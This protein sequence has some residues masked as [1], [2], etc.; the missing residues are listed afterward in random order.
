MSRDTPGAIRRRL[1]QIFGSS[2]KVQQQSSKSLTILDRSEE[3]EGDYDFRSGHG[4][5]SK[6]KERPKSLSVKDRS[7]LYLTAA[8]PAPPP[9]ILKKSNSCSTSKRKSSKPEVRM[10]QLL[11]QTFNR[12]TEFRIVSAAEFHDLNVISS[13]N[14]LPSLSRSHSQKQV[15]QG[16]ESKLDSSDL[17]A[18]TLSTISTIS[19]RLSLT[20]GSIDSTE[21]TVSP[22][23]SLS[24]ERRDLS[25]DEDNE[26]DLSSLNNDNAEATGLTTSTLDSPFEFGTAEG[27][28]GDDNNNDKDN[29]GDDDDDDNAQQQLPEL[30]HLSEDS[31]FSGSLSFKQ[32]PPITRAESPLQDAEQ[33]MRDLEAENARLLSE[34]RLLTAMVSFRE[35]QLLQAKVAATSVYKTL[36]PFDSSVPPLSF[37]GNSEANSRTLHHP[38]ISWMA[39]LSL[40]AY[41]SPMDTRRLLYDVWPTK[42]LP[43]PSRL[44]FFADRDSDTWAYGYSYPSSG[45]AAIVFR[46]TTSDENW[47]TNMNIKMT[48][49]VAE[50]GPWK[51]ADLPVGDMQ[52]HSGFNRA[53]QSVWPSIKRFIHSF[54]LKNT[55]FSLTGHSLGGALASLCYIYIT[56]FYP[57]VQVVQAV[58]FGQPRLANASVVR[59][60][61]AHGRCVLHRIRNQS[62]GVPLIPP[63]APLGFTHL[64]GVV[65]LTA[66]GMIVQNKPKAQ[67]AALRYGKT[68]G[69]SSVTDHSMLE[70]VSLITRG[71]NTMM[72]IGGSLSNSDLAQRTLFARTLCVNLS[73]LDRFK[74]LRS[75]VRYTISVFNPK[76]N[77]IRGQTDVVNQLDADTVPIN[78]IV[79][80]YPV[81]IGDLFVVHIHKS[82]H[83]RRLI[84]AASFSIHTAQ[85]RTPEFTLPM[86]YGKDRATVASLM[87]SFELSSP[88]SDESG[89]IPEHRKRLF[90]HSLDTVC[91]L[92]LHN[93]PIDRLVSSQRA[94]PDVLAVF[95]DAITKRALNVDS[96]FDGLTC[97][98]FWNKLRDAMHHL[99]LSYF[100]LDEPPSSAM[101]LRSFA[102]FLRTLSEPICTFALYPRWLITANSP[103]RSALVTAL[104]EEMPSLNAR[105]LRFTV[106][107]ASLIA[108]N[109]LHTKISLNTLAEQLAPLVFY[110]CHPSTRERLHVAEH[111]PRFASLLAY[112]VTHVDEHWPC[113]ASDPLCAVSPPSSSLSLSSSTPTSM[114]STLTV[115]APVPSQ[116]NGSAIIDTAEFQLPRFKKSVVVTLTDSG[117]LTFYEP[118]SPT[119]AFFCARLPENH[120]PVGLFFDVLRNSL[121][122][123]MPGGAPALLP[124]DNAL[125]WL[126]GSADLPLHSFSGAPSRVTR[127]V[128]HDDNTWLATDQG[129]LYVVRG[130]HR[131][132]ELKARTAAGCRITCLQVH[133]T[134]TLLIGDERQALYRYASIAGSAVR[135]S[136][137]PVVDLVPVVEFAQLTIDPHSAS[138]SSQV[139]PCI[140]AQLADSDTGSMLEDIEFLSGITCILGATPSQVW[141]CSSGSVYVL[142]SA[143]KLQGQLAVFPADASVFSI[144]RTGPATYL[145]AAARQFWTF[146]H[147]HHHFT[148]SSP[149]PT[150]AGLPARQIVPVP[151]PFSSGFFVNLTTHAALLRWN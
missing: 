61:Q 114:L 109:L 55:R 108:A 57:Q 38:S 112:L 29:E 98:Q 4:K 19:D 82:E 58:T 79:S 22:R 85:T 110:T 70:Y 73:S 150:V 51:W 95:E 97:D 121:M 52:V 26:D 86:Y 35:T 60:L 43:Q 119:P 78:T 126:E 143:L 53:F 101:I 20:S 32:L 137:A 50:N 71:I 123:L 129:E 106:R 45:E 5:T 1:G 146:E 36:E 90:G 89:A 56:A 2:E 148:L 125:D 111:L 8:N 116:Y 140:G 46:G 34:N 7:S 41:Y 64:A 17:T 131:V 13:Q 104:L 151:L 48:K 100:F 96:A 65:Y 145:A 74:R 69:T 113:S 134:D 117:F 15:R 76:A 141:V 27:D 118:Y 91:A 130:K 93:Y 115:L 18:S 75:S 9:S 3:S 102:E 127:C 37:V 47:R 136:S 28:S 84:A 23:V 83:R 142:D 10:C 80:L 12:T 31:R 105:V 33:R 68:F 6:K 63:K 147:S 77:V 40:L 49:L 120:R 59:F 122:L 25:G 39:N 42:G 30:F 132:A 11:K 72:R 62:D 16:S 24:D 67:S 99:D 139:R 107:I 44:E 81:F 103:E 133:G 144:S 14:E 138:A 135:R 124:L 87:L 66:E 21:D 128:Q 88:N 149:L 54:D 94:L 92:E